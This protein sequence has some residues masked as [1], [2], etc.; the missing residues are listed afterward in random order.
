MKKKIT[1]F[2]RFLTYTVVLY[3]IW[4]PVGKG[5]LLLIAWV[6]KYVLWFMGYHVELVLD[7]IP[8]FICNE[9]IID[10]KD[11]HLSNFTIVPLVALI[12]AT[13]GI[14]FERKLNMFLI[15]IF[16]LFCLHTIFFVIHFP[17]YLHSSQV[18]EA[19]MVFMA[20][21]NMAVPFIIWFILAYKEIIEQNPR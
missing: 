6:S 16:T 1:F 4:I 13:P 2:I 5:Y 14:E 20:I 15:G 18:A 19:I 17:M 10:M 8:Y 7:G 12:L 3:I 21:C 9:S 11:T